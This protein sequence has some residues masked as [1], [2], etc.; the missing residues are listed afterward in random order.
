MDWTFMNAFEIPIK[1]IIVLLLIL[2]A[3]KVRSAMKRAYKSQY[4]DPT[5]PANIWFYS[6][7]VNMEIGETKPTQK[8]LNECFMKYL[9][10]K[11][12]IRKHHLEKFTIFQIV[13]Q[14][15]EDPKYIE[16]YGEIWNSI[17]ELKQKSKGE[18]LAYIKTIKTAFNKER[19][20]EWVKNREASKEDCNDC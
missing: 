17:Q 12:H 5:M 16:L 8:N 7:L 9:K 1:I 11:Y 13:A 3:I 10:R 18:V 14:R 15:E 20:D 2:I 6:E 4:G 19:I